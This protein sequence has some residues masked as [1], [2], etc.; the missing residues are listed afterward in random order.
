MHI[1]F[2]ADT[3]AAVKSQGMYSFGCK[4][5][6]WWEADHC[7]VLQFES[8]V[9]Y[10]RYECGGKREVADR[11]VDQ[12]ARSSA[13]N[14][15]LAVRLRLRIKDVEEEEEYT[16]FDWMRYDRMDVHDLPLPRTGQCVLSYNHNRIVK[17]RTL[18]VEY[19]ML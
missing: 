10:H 16:V 18:P 7:A 2:S 13:R 6:V 3:K 1:A 4:L 15:R 12:S 19:S 8:Y 11:G 5:R 14:S 17:S 9:Q